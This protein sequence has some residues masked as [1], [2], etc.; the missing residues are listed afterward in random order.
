M[1]STIIVL[2]TIIAQRLSIIIEKM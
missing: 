1:G 2:L